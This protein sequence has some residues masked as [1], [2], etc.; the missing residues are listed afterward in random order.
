MKDTYETMYKQYKYMHWSDKKAIV[1]E[2]KLNKTKTLEKEH[3][4][5]DNKNGEKGFILSKTKY[6]W[7]IIQ[8]STQLAQETIKNIQQIE[9][10]IGKLV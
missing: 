2:K 3:L 10:I 6:S 9:Y 5:W 7:I 8:V 1:N 4:L